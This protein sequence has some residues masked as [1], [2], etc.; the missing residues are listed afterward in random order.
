MKPLRHPRAVIADWATELSARLSRP[1]VELL[2]GGLQAGDFDPC[3]FVEVRDPCGMT[4]RVSFAFAL[5]R[6]ADNVAVV[7]SEHCGY[8]E[9]DLVADMVVA[10]IREELY[11][12]HRDE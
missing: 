11:T 2:S 8:M 9:F 3:S 1:A 12:H 5:V 6:P 4:T 7:F 10:E